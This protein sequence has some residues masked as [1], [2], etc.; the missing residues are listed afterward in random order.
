M[1][2]PALV[3]GGAEIP[4]TLVTQT[5]NKRADILAFSRDD[6]RTFVFVRN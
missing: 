3:V 6:F 1:R 2:V 4:T 5:V